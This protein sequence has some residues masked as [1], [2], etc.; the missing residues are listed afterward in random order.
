MI[1]EDSIYLKHILNAISKIEEYTKEKSVKE[2]RSAS[3]IQ[4]IEEKERK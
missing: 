4:I 3:I 1:K 2:F